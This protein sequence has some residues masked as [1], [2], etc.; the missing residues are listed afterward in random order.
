MNRFLIFLV[1]LVSTVAS[2]AATPCWINGMTT[3]CIKPVATGSGGTGIASTA[4]YPASG[5]VVVQGGALGTPSSAT[6]TGATGL[7]LTTGVTGLLPPANGGTGVNNAGTLTYGASNVTLTTTGATNVT[8][9][10]AGTLA[11]ND[12]SNL[13]SVSVNQDLVPNSNNAINLGTSGLTWSN[14]WGDGL[15]LDD[16]TGTGKFLTLFRHSGGSSYS[17]E[18]PSTGPSATSLLQTDNLGNISFTTTPTLGTPA[19]GTLTNATGLPIVGGTTGTLTV[20]RGGTGL[21]TLTANGVVY[22]GTSTTNITAQGAANSV[23]VANAGAP[24]FSQ[25]PTINTSL[26]VGV[27]ASQAGTLLLANG[28]GSGASV[29]VQNPS[30]TTGYNFN[31]PAT[32]GSSGQPMLSAG[33]ASAAMTFGTLGVGAGGTGL[34]AGTSGGV[35]AYTASGTLASSAA[36]LANAVVVGGGAGA[37]PTQVTNNA[38]ATNEFLTQSSSGLPAYATILAA[39]IPNHSAA[40]ITSGTLAVAQGGTNLASGTSGGVLGYTASGTLASS[41][42]LTANGVVI[43]GGAGATPTATAAGTNGQLLV[44]VTSGAPAW[45]NTVSAATSF[46]AAAADAV[47]VTGAASVT[48]ATADFS[49]KLGLGLKGATSTNDYT[50]LDFYVDGTSNLGARIAATGDGSGS[51][52]TIATT[53]SYGGTGTVGLKMKPDGSTSVN[54]LSTIAMQTSTSA[55]CSASPCTNDVTYP[56]GAWGTGACARNSGGNYTCT[57]TASWFTAAPVCTVNQTHQNAVF[58][59]ALATSSNVV[60]LCFNTAAAATDTRLGV[61]CVGPR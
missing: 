21:T 1:V 56:S 18:F 9:P 45:G 3:K 50:G 40:K 46:T 39:D 7:P 5:V 42:A 60:I 31:L 53:S 10:T 22:G 57:W 58:C 19:S 29:T 44:G 12:L 2:G 33:G 32:A 8:L 47:D 20:A 35:P 24:S 48:A 28:G 38:S 23:L 11:K 41:A 6:L 61:V 51:T 49:K 13:A 37:V 26:T 43:G 34:T 36:L 52:L 14:I 59:S 16:G 54:G 27:N 30:A 17:L 55:D 25:T 15:N 4:T